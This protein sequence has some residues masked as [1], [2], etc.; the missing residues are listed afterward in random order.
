MILVR[1]FLG[2]GGC[3]GLSGWARCHHKGPYKKDRREAKGGGSVTAER[4][5]EAMYLKMKEEATSQ[6]I[7]VATRS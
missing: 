2:G 3:F 1:I 6:G 7:Q 5:T 4:E